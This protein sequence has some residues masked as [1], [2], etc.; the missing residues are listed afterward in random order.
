MKASAEIFC[1]LPSERSELRAPCPRRRQSVRP[2]AVN[3]EQARVC[4]PDTQELP[5][6]QQ[7]AAKRGVRAGPGQQAADMIVDA[8]RSALSNRCGRLLS[9]E[10]ARA[11]L[12][13][14]SCFSGTMVSIRVSVSTSR[15]AP[16]C[17][18]ASPS[19]IGSSPPARSRVS[20]LKQHVARI[21]A[22]IDPHGRHA[23][24]WSRRSQWP[25]ERAPRRAISAAATHAH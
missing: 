9:S 19:S 3:R 22:G 21:E 18:G 14:S 15:S 16:R 6:M 23:G 7:L 24:H 17:E 5:D 12:A 2:P 11:W 25:I 20:A 1:G 8:L 4:A 10:W 13:A